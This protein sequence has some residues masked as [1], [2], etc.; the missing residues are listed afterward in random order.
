MRSGVQKSSMY[1]LA[2]SSALEGQSP[3]K[4]CQPPSFHFRNAS[5][6]RSVGTP[7]GS[8]KPPTVVS[9]PPS[10][11]PVSMSSPAPAWA[12][13]ESEA[14]APLSSVLLQAVVVTMT[15]TITAAAAVSPRRRMN[16]MEPVPRV[17]ETC[18]APA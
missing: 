12:V 1:G 10:F 11:S 17:T 5:P 16:D 8:L 9:P 3:P 13:V 4:S 14:L 18:H 15:A 2:K 6:V 7:S